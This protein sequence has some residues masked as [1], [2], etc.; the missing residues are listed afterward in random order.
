[1]SWPQSS[2]VRLMVTLGYLVWKAVIMPLIHSC[3]LPPQKSD[4]FSVTLPALATSVE[5]DDAAAVVAGAFP[6]GAHPPNASSAAMTVAAPKDLP[7]VMSLFTPCSFASVPAP[8]GGRGMAMRTSY[9][10]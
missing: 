5:T 2:C 3:S 7:T 1:M 6:P 9:T 10:R 8:P 4:R